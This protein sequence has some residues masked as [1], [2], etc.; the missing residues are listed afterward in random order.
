MTDVY[1]ISL[2]TL[3]LGIHQLFIRYYLKEFRG[4]N[5]ILS[6]VIKVYLLKGALVSCEFFGN[7]CLVVLLKN[8]VSNET[9]MPSVIRNL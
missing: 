1:L 9:V 4:R 6:R 3:F 7:S 8:L 5:L 2:D